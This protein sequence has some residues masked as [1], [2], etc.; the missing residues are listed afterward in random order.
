MDVILIQDAL[1][2]ALQVHTLCVDTFTLPVPPKHLKL[3]LV[4]DI[5]YVQVVVVVVVVFGTL[6]DVL[7]DVVGRTVVV[8]VGLS[9]VVL[10][11]VVGCTVVVVVGLSDVVLLEVVGSIVEVVVVT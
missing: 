9:D 3:L 1:L 10:L 11:E 7:L 4:G 8:V 6:D 5:E 2:V